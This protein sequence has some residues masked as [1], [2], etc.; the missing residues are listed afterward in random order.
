MTLRSQGPVLGSL[1]TMFRGEVIGPD[2]RGYDIARKVQNGM[3]DKRPAVIAR[4]TGVADVL[5]AL[6]FGLEQNLPIAIR[7]AGHNVAG[8][9]VCDDGIVLDL[10]PMKGIRVGP[11]RRLAQAQ[12][13]CTWGS[14]TGRR[15]RSGKA[16]GPDGRHVRLVRGR[17]G[18]SLAGHR[19]A[20]P[21]D[22]R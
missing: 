9:A 14:S 19:H 21:T 15:R 5:A 20:R 4:C 2:D 6:Q 22:G 8:M 17:P 12:A 1:R 11:A 10:A 18:R 7:G 16:L 13:G 3:I